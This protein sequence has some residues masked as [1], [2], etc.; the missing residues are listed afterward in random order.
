M[1]F[2]SLTQHGQK[3]KEERKRRREQEETLHFL[4]K[5]NKKQS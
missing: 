3:P 2:I 1:E 4:V 5:F